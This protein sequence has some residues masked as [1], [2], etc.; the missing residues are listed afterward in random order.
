MACE[1]NHRARYTH[2]F[3][4]EDCQTFFG[5]DSRTYRSGELL[6]NLYFALHNLNIQHAGGCP[7][8]VAMKQKIGIGV[9]HDNYEELITEAIAILDRYGLD[10]NSATVTLR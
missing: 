6:S 5:H 3:Y 2:G 9:K 8:A 4:C 10:E 7:E 1:H